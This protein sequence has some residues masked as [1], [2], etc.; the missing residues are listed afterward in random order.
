MSHH[1][2]AKGYIG[3]KWE[4]PGQPAGVKLKLFDQK[5]KTAPTF[6]IYRAL[7]ALI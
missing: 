1:R 2:Y 5:L 3:M 7:G 6:K 4:H